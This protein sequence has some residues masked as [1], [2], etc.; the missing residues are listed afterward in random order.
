MQNRYRR[1]FIVFRVLEALSNGISSLSV[2]SDNQDAD[3]EHIRRMFNRKGEDIRVSKDPD[4][5]RLW[6]K[7]K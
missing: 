7:R 5:K 4:G 6:F 1:Q 3:Q 2:R